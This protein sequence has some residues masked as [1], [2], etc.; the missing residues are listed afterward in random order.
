[1]R[2]IRYRFGPPGHQTFLP[3][4]WPH[5]RARINLA[6]KVRNFDVTI[7]SI[8]LQLSMSI[9]YFN[10]SISTAQVK[11][12]GHTFK[13]QTSIIRR[14]MKRRVSWQVDIQEATP[15]PWFDLAMI[16]IVEP[17]CSLWTVICLA[18]SASLARLFAVYITSG[19]SQP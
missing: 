14:N 6:V 17:C 15:L 2:W 12:A 10:G 9:G 18:A 11:V 5:P 1:M 4:R 3:G 19:L 16:E 13:T 8:H 7:A